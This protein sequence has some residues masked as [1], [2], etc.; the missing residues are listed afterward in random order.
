MTVC[1]VLKLM[2]HIYRLLCILDMV[3]IAVCSN[4][5]QVNYHKFNSGVVKQKAGLYVFTVIIVQ[6]HALFT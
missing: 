2:S 4:L 5:E 1:A 3:N 6:L